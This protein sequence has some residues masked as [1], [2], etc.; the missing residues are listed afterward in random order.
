MKQHRTDMVSLTFALIFLAIS[1]WWLLA[2]TFHLSL[3]RV[4]WFVAG[5][6]ILFGLVGILGALRSNPTPLPDD[7]STDRG[8]PPVARADSP[9]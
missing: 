2:Q 9:R 1:A 4:G 7:D 8:S 6:L 5:A 3:P